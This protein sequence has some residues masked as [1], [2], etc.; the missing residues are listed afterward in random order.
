MSIN[1]LTRVFFVLGD[2][3]AQ[4]R[5]PQLFNP[6]FR[7]FGENAVLV[8]AHVAPERC[9]AFVRGVL[10]AG[11]MDGLW[12]TIPHKTAALDWLDHCN[13]SGRR[14]AAVNAVRR[15]PD[16]SLEGALFDGLG[17]AKALDHQGVATTGQRVLLVGTGGA[18]MAIAAALSERPLAELAL[19]DAQPGRA[20]ALAARLQADSACPLSTPG[21]LDPAGF[22]LVV[23]ATPLGLRADDP[24][25]FAVQALDPGAVVFDILMKTAG[26]PLQRACEAAGVRYHPGFDMLVQQVPDYLRF[27][28]FES[29]AATLEWDLAPV[30]ALITSD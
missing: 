1:G 30:R 11:N 13:P 10:G 25:P 19:Y 22:S 8:P 23:H 14:A 28:G 9:E 20:S 17:L 5:A 4:V 29:M 15:R 27:F 6:L 7:R 2:P 21:Q 16:A 12:L 18:G 24:L 3:V 26:T